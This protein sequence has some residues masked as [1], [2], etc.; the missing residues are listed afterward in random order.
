M[1]TYADVC[2]RMLPVGG[3]GGD[4]GSKLLGVR[5]LTY[6]DVCG[7]MLLLG[8]RGGDW[9]SKMAVLDTNFLKPCPWLVD[10]MMQVCC[11]CGLMLL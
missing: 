8:G 10:K 9:G 11:R 7:R 5:M 3:R 4:W 2:G 6:A 1:L